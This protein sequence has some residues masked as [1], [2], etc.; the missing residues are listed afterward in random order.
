MISGSCLSEGWDL[1]RFEFCC[2]GGGYAIVCEPHDR[3]YMPPPC[4]A[5]APTCPRW[6]PLWPFRLTLVQPEVGEGTQ[7]P[8]TLIYKQSFGQQVPSRLQMLQGKD[9]MEPMVNMQTRAAAF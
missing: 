1:G 3:T 2:G 7:I 9:P 6:T 8:D 4:S 5:V